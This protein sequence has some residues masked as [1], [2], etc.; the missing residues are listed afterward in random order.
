[1]NKFLF[2]LDCIISLFNPCLPLPRIKHID[3]SYL[4]EDTGLSL[5]QKAENRPQAIELSQGQGKDDA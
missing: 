1:L 2:V 5:L 3:L 4:D